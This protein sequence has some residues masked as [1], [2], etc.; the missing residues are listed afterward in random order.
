LGIEEQFYIF[1]PILLVAAFRLRASV[2]QLT[3]ILLILS[4]LVNV[5]GVHRFPSAT[6]YSI[7]SRAWELVFGALLAHLSLQKISVFFAG[8][9]RVFQAAESTHNGRGPGQRCGLQK[10]VS[11]STPCGNIAYW[12]K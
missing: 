10:A 9:E 6:F 11:A 12:R 8:V 5:A 7:A 3:L 4:L 2:L 1:W